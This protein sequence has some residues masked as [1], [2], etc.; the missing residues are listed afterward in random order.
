MRRNGCGGF[1]RYRPFPTSVRTGRT[2]RPRV[3][4]RISAT[5][6]RLPMCATRSEK[7]FLRPFVWAPFLLLLRAMKTDRLPRQARDRN[8]SKEN[9]QEINK[10][11]VFVGRIYLIRQ[12]CWH[13]QKDAGLERGRRCLCV[14]LRHAR[15][16]GLQIRRAGPADRRYLA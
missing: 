15:H 7:R 3:A 6:C 9:P 1:L 16:A 12:G 13:Q 10:G 14:R 4:T 2:T 8:R 11:A 5:V